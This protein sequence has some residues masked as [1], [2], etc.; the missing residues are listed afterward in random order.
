MIQIAVVFSS[1]EKE[2][3]VRRRITFPVK[4]GMKLSYVSGAGATDNAL[5]QED[6]GLSGLVV[7]VASGG[8]EALIQDLVAGTRKPALLLANPCR[9]SLAAAME[10]YAVLKEDCPV[11]LAYAEHGSAAE[12]AEITRFVWV[13]RALHHLH[14]ARL[15]CLGAPSDWLLTS[16]AVDG[17][18]TLGTELVHLAMEELLRRLR[19]TD[20]ERGR[21]LSGTYRHRFSCRDVGPPAVDQAARLALAVEAMARDH[22]LDGVTIRCFDLLA[23][24]VTACLGVS[25]L[26]DAGLPAGCEGDLPAALTLMAASRLTSQPAWMANPARLDPEANTVTLAHCSV[27]TRLLEERQPMTL[28]PHMESGLSAALEGS[29]RKGLATLLRFSSDAAELLIA[30]GEVESSG[31]EEPDMCR[32][33]AV[34]RMEGSVANWLEHSPGNHQILVYGHHQQLLADFCRFGRIRPVLIT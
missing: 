25:R 14:H 4:E 17:F 12:Q 5:F 32:T 8:T 2:E 21:E 31:G 16:R 24:G 19:M 30:P 11:K 33:R 28:R 18:D 20:P 26:N 29:L 34:F 1:L 7:V 22:A 27:P 3:D 15:G 6:D 23:H 13:A 9:N 10:A